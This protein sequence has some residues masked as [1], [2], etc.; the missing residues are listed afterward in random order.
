MDSSLPPITVTP[1]E[2]QP[3]PGKPIKDLP[4]KKKPFVPSWVWWAMFL[5]LIFVGLYELGVFNVGEK[6]AVY[7]YPE[8][9]MQ[10]SVKVNVNGF[11]IRSIPDY[12]NGWNVHATT[13]GLI[14]GKYDYLFYE[15]TL[16]RLDA[17]KEGWIVAYDDL[18]SWFDAKLPELGLNDAESKEFKKYWLAK[19]PRKN[20]YQI[21]LLSDSFLK[22]DMDLIVEPK[23]DTVIRRMFCFKPLNEKRIISEP[24][25]A[26][27]ERN[28]FTVVEWGGIMDLN[29]VDKALYNLESLLGN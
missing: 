22:S 8:H 18:S 2:N 20:Y 4:V 11:I 9:D 13:S 14:D 25:I 17:P 19:L 23:P 12:N 24:T 3:D 6:P 7:L 28:G 1:S 21:G 26:K 15:N 10:V 16:S 5:L 27:V 29:P